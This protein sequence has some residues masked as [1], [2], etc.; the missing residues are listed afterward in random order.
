[1]KIFSAKF[2]NS[3]FALNFHFYY[4]YVNLFFKIFLLYL[5]YIL[6]FIKEPDRTNIVVAVRFFFEK[7]NF[8]KKFS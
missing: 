1:M 6:F 5:S 8:E 3:I 4:I 2:S 7:K